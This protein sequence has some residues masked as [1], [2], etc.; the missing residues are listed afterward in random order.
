MYSLL[1]LGFISFA[2]SLLLTPLVR[3]LS[4]HFGIVDQPDQQRKIHASPVPRMGGVAIFASVL[5]AFGLL[6]VARFSSGSIV[7]DGLP[8]VLRLLPAFV[9]VFT[10]GLIDDIF[11]TRPWQRLAV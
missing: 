9:I 11:S 1:F 6:L 5:L 8:L 3:N 10:I 4:W 2:L 7:W